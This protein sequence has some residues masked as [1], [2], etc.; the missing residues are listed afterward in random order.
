M[1][2]SAKQIC[3]LL[4]VTVS[5]CVMLTEE[6][7]VFWKYPDVP[8][9]GH[10]RLRST[11]RYNRDHS[12]LM[13]SVSGYIIWIMTSLTTRINGH[14][15]WLCRFVIGWATNTLHSRCRGP[16]GPAVMTLLLFPV[17]VVSWVYF[18][19]KHCS[20]VTAVTLCRSFVVFRHS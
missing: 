15:D 6:E 10:T 7:N 14:F 11:V 19:L 1:Y 5:S 8:S 13:W 16:L 2:C 9:Y 3:Y 12:T 17:C 4:S 18:S 20:T